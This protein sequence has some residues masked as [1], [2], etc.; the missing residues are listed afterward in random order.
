MSNWAGPFEARNGTAATY[1]SSLAPATP[2]ELVKGEAIAIRFFNENS[3]F[4]GI[5]SLTEY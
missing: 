1:T 4:D 5:Q 2:T 3:T